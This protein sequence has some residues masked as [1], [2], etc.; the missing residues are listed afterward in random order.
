MTTLI[1]FT[2]VSVS[3]P[4]IVIGLILA[5]L[6]YFLVLWLL[7]LLSGAGAAG[8]GVPPRGRWGLAQPI[9]AL[10]ALLVFLSCAFDV[11]S[12]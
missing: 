5:A 10:L 2:H 1:A 9:A 3:I 6:V 4:G 11:W 8:P 12:S 7:G